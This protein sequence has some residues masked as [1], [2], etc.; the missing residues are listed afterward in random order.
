MNQYDD[1]K[2]YCRMLGHQISFSYCRTMND[3][4]PCGKVL[5][6]WH[7]TFPVEEFINSHYT[8]DER[9]RMFSP[10]RSR[11]ETIIDSINK[12]KKNG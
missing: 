10:P 5:D 9:N 6:C 7:E 12:S 3:S 2:N 4:L 11:I 8:D 1:K